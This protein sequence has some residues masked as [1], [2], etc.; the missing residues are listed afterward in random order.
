MKQYPY[1]TPQIL[2]DSQF[3]L[4]GGRTGTSSDFQREIAYSL[5]EEQMTEYIN[6]FILPTTVT[7]TY[8]WKGTNPVIL[9]YGHVSQI[10]QVVFSSVDWANSCAIETVTGCHA[11]RGD[12][13][14]GYLDVQYLTSCG[15]CTSILGLPPL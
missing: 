6:A 4:Y 14:Y 8:F 12:G 7:G 11:L 15:G 1:N 9:D 3:L 10:N 2:N 5:A 13:T